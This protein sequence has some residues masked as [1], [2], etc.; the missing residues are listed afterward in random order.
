MSHLC[1]HPSSPLIFM[2]LSFN[3]FRS[4]VLRNVPPSEF[5]WK[6]PHDSD[7]AL[8]AKTPLQWRFLAP[9]TASFGGT[10]HQAGPL[11]RC[12]EQDLRGCHCWKSPEWTLSAPLWLVAMCDVE[13]KTIGKFC[14]SML[15]PRGV[16]ASRTVPHLNRLLH[17][18]VYGRGF[19]ILPSS[20]NLLAGIL[21]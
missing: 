14:P 5:I 18:E 6:F 9:P 3:E 11:S 10:W 1:R 16:L 17:W 12:Q 19:L 2:D 15:R 20:L 13:L 7:K 8:L 21:P 4:A